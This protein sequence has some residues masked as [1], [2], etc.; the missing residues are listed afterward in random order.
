MDDLNEKS[1][2][3]DD[4]FNKLRLESILEK[5]HDGLNW[6]FVFLLPLPQ[7]RKPKKNSMYDSP[8]RLIVTPEKYLKYRDILE[9]CDLFKPYIE[10]LS[11]PEFI[12]VGFCY[13]PDDKIKDLKTQISEDT[14]EIL[15]FFSG[16]W[17]N[18]ETKFDSIS[19]KL[20]DSLM[21]DITS[22]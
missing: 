10:Y 6:K 14:V 3:V 12:E 15:N 18:S 2:N 9:N 13:N 1:K 16:S 21:E 20:Q 4:M 17:K 19:P 7:K 11:N 8:S 5:I 22:G